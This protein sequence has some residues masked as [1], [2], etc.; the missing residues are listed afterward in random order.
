MQ[1][2]FLTWGLTLALLTGMACS[3]GAQ[4]WAIKADQA[5]ACSCDVPCPCRFG[6]PPTLGYCEANV[7]TEIEEGHYGD[8]RLDGIP[9]VMTVRVGDW[10]KF[11][12]S[13]SATDEQAKAAEQLLMNSISFLAGMKVLSNEK[14]PVSIERAANKVRFSVP[15]STV[16]TEMME[17]LDGKPI[18]I[19]NL[20]VPEESDF[21]QYKT[22]TNSHKSDDKEF[23]YSGKNGSTTRIEASSAK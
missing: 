10:V 14:V 7:L 19:Q 15:A 13:E 20:P 22:I 3:A 18:K 2:Q 4:D 21:T 16:E 8:V 1:K 11:Y 6:S 12:V 17:G 9:V 5:S 23:S